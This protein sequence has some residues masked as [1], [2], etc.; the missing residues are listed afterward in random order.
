[1]ACADGCRGVEICVAAAVYAR[2]NAQGGRGHPAVDLRLVGVLQLPSDGVEDA[3]EGVVCYSAT[4]ERVC[5]QGAEGV[6]ADLVVGGR[7]ALADEVEVS[8]G[9]EGGSVEEDE[10]CVW[11]EV[12]L[13]RE[14][15]SVV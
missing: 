8:V 1:M 7:C 13:E 4:E 12:G 6:V 3:G 9:V 15:E 5:G 11:T 10:P 14:E 2:R